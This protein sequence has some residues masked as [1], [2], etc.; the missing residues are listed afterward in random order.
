MSSVFY[1]RGLTIIN[2]LRIAATRSTRK[3]RE[4]FSSFNPFLSMR[5]LRA[6][7]TLGP[8]MPAHAHAKE[9]DHGVLV[10]QNSYMYVF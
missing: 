4:I 10:L 2:F 5:L 6:R 9:K 1:Q 8:N 7:V 3:N